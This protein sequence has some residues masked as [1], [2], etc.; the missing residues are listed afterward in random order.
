[1]E[2]RFGGQARALFAL[3]DFLGYEEYNRLKAVWATKYIALPEKPEA[4]FLRGL[5]DSGFI[6]VE[7][8]DLLVQWNDVPACCQAVLPVPPPSTGTTT[9][10]TTSTPESSVPT[11]VESVPSIVIPA[12]Y[13]VLHSY[14]AEDDPNKTAPATI[15]EVCQRFSAK[16]KKLVALRVVL[17][18]DL[19]QLSSVKT[20]PKSLTIALDKSGSMCDA[21]ED[22]KKSVLGIIQGARACG[23]E[24]IDVIFY[25]SRV[26]IYPCKGKP[27]GDIERDFKSTRASGGT[28]FVEAFRAV[29]DIIAR[30][31][32]SNH[33][34]VFFSDGQ[35]GC[36]KEQLQAQYNILKNLL[37]NSSMS[38]EVHSIGFT[39]GHDAVLLGS[40]P[41]LGTTQGTFQ[42]IKTA[43]EIEGATNTITNLLGCQQI[44]ASIVTPAKHTHKLVLDYQ[45]TGN[46]SLPWDEVNIPSPVFITLGDAMYPM[47]LQK[48]QNKMKIEIAYIESEISRLLN[49]IL[50][51]KERDKLQHIKELAES[52]DARVDKMLLEAMK[53][54]SVE[55]KLYCKELLRVKELMVTFHKFLAE[56]ITGTLTNDK[57]ASFTSMTYRNITKSGLSKKLDQRAEKNVSLMEDLEL[58]MANAAAAI[59]VAALNKKKAERDIRCAISTR[60]WVECCLD[61]DC[62]CIALSVTRSEAAIADPT[63]LNVRAVHQTYI[64]ADTFMES[65][66]YSIE[67]KESQ[68]ASHGGFTRSI[69]SS[70]LK[71]VAREDIT[72]CI[73]L[74]ISPEHWS[75][76]KHKMKSICGWLCTLD[77]LGYAYSQVTTIPFLVLACLIREG[78]EGGEFKQEQFQLVMETCEAIYQECSLKAEV[79]GKVESYVSNP[80]TR[81]I[82][83]IPSSLVFLGQVFTGLRLGDLVLAPEILPPFFSAVC[84]EEIRRR[85]NATAFSVDNI[86]V[87]DILNLFDVDIE[88]FVE[89]PTRIWEQEYLKTLRSSCAVSP[90]KQAFLAS[91]SAQSPAPA[92][93][94]E[95]APDTKAVSTT[96]PSGASSTAPPQP[97]K[98]DAPQFS[99]AD[100][101]LS[102]KMTEFLEYTDKYVSWSLKLVKQF[103]TLFS[104][105]TK[106]VLKGT[107]PS[108][109]TIVDEPIQRFAIYLQSYTH[110]KNAD[111]RDAITG[112]TFVPFTEMNNDFCMNHCIKLIE[113]EAA[114]QRNK[115]VNSVIARES[116]A[117]G[118]RNAAVF[119]TTYDL[120]EAAGIMLVECPFVGKKAFRQ[121][122]ESFIYPGC[123]LVIEKLKMLLSGHYSG[124]K[125]LCDKNATTPPFSWAPGRQTLHSIW[126]VHRNH[127]PDLEWLPVHPCFSHIPTWTARG[128]FKPVTLKVFNV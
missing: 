31:D 105:P 112:G 123:V 88:K 82:D 103:E 113:T 13:C 118:S 111:R 54:K 5:V 94:P 36:G 14:S 17:S 38:N 110:R 102:P 116:G 12:T 43:S 32:K 34:V 9:S 80:A 66:R 51:T 62:M 98:V 42:Y 125:I 58:K 109:V 45:R 70:V 67:A 120:E 126:A 26:S 61:A 1:M 84:E 15:C 128:G 78:N 11:P 40:I 29:G 64:S 16:G 69:D 30:Y 101:T 77:V 2:E 53:L 93:T 76:A 27:F 65:L 25:D 41:Q 95:A 46:I 23:I 114:L 68:E 119:A 85:M 75:V 63:Q 104:T 106:V 83:V 121:I 20:V 52:S 49:Q 91:K 10:T 107:A 59:D 4:Q 72:G 71:G 127:I 60:D 74:W 96:E 50:A 7:E 56:A 39:S 48:E 117:S 122:K 73:P 21:I 44:A 3:R 18:A 47:K 19:P 124:V 97:L 22:A 108:S 81:T 100:F 55:R 57:I 35:D 28:S 87:N 86:G 24:D 33:A 37:S 90:W 8:H 99:P 92:K 115:R 79:V 6:S 89:Q